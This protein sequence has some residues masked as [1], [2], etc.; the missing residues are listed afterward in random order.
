MFRTKLI[1][2]TMAAVIALGTAGVAFASSGEHENSKVIS[3][4][5]NAKPSIS[6]AIAAAEKQTGG[7]AMKADV[8]HEKGAYL[9]E[10]K[11]VSKEK[12]SEVFVDPASGKITRTDDEGFIAKIFHKEDQAEFAKLAASPVTLATAVATAEKETG[13]KAVEAA[14]EN[15]DGKMLFE[16]EIAKDKAVHKVMIGSTAWRLGLKSTSKP[17][18]QRPFAARRH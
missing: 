12:V 2:A 1:P 7:R 18:R 5:L 9:Y 15:E 3:A 6:Q 14:F 11:T 10:I 17:D 4:V 13:C 8:E 16:V